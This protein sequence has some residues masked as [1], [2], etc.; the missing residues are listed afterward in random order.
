LQKS[1]ASATELPA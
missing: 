1:E